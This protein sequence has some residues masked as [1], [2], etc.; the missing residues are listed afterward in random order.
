MKVSEITV[1]NIVSFLHLEKGDYNPEEIEAILIAAK[2]YVANY[3]GIPQAG[4]TESDET[5]DDH[6]DFYTVVMVLC[7]DMHDNRSYAADIK[8]GESQQGVNFV[9]DSILGMHARNLL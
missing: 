9:V 8:Y 5:L 3:T 6:P 2:Q 4:N 7:Q 1:D